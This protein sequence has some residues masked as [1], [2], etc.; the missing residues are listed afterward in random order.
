MTTQPRDLAAEVADIH[1]RDTLL[2]HIAAQSYE[3]EDQRKHIRDWRHVV[4]CLEVDKERLQYQID[5]QAKDLDALQKTT[6]KLQPENELLREAL[7]WV[8]TNGVVMAIHHIEGNRCPRL[9]NGD[10]D[11]AHAP[12]HLRVVLE[13][14]MEG[15]S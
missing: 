2:A 14:A 13:K 12:A 9:V 11:S 8:L 15:R 4:M 10:C 6:R 3:L 7:R 1:D 5:S